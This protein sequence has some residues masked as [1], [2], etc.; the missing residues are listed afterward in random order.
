MPRWSSP[1]RAISRA[2]PPSRAIA[3]A[4]LVAMP[5]ATSSIAVGRIF[6]GPSGSRST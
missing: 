2:C 5:C 6:P 3:V 4:A 1:I